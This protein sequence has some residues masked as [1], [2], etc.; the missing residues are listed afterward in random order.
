MS[1]QPSAL[2]LAARLPPGL[3][4]TP[5]TSSACASTV[6]RHL[7][8]AGSQN[9][10]VPSALPLTTASPVKLMSRPAMSPLWPSYSRTHASF[11]APA[12]SPP[13]A[14][15][16]AS[17]PADAMR[18]SH[19]R[20]EASHEPDSRLVPSAS[21]EMQDTG[22]VCPANVAS[23][24]PVSTSHSF[25]CVSIDA[26]ATCRPSGLNSTFTTSPVWPSNTPTQSPVCGFHSRA[27]VSKEPETTRLPKGL[28]NATEKTTF[29][30][31]SS[32][33]SFVASPVF[34]TR[35]VLS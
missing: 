13:A 31:P 24:E 6:V 21:N 23:A 17:P 20:S 32:A 15:P 33:R 27:V 26:V 7:P 1:T 19:A 35:H 11:T 28:L 34:H 5:V 29:E 4:A 10:T 22:A 16:P 14:P 12:P 18:G 3:K 8:V 30:W 9:L 25:T 2:E